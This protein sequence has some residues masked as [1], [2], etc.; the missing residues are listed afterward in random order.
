MGGDA[1]Y[2]IYLT[3]FY[4]MSLA[5]DAWWALKWSYL[6]WALSTTGCAAAAA[7]GLVAYH[8]IERPI[9]RDLRK[10]RWPVKCLAPAD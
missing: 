3:H 2:S 10:L 1:S 5:A 6:P 7:G 8:A 9:L 4:S